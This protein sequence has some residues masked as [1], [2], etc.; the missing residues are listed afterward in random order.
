MLLIP[1]VP[2]SFS[3]KLCIAFCLPWNSQV[4]QGSAAHIQQ[5]VRREEEGREHSGTAPFFWVV[6]RGKLC[7][8]WDCTHQVLLSL[9][10]G[11]NKRQPRVVLC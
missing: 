4:A 2:V 7:G 8:T 6:V 11:K 5:L 3:V 9:L 10:L 1:Q